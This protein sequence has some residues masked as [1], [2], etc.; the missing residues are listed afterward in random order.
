MNKVVVWIGDSGLGHDAIKLD[1]A[2]DGLGRNCTPKPFDCTIEPLRTWV[3][4]EPVSMY[5]TALLDCLLKSD[6]NVRKGIEHVLNTEG[7]LGFFLEA[8][9]ALAQSWETLFR[10]PDEFFS[11]KPKWR[12][13]RLVKPDEDPE[14]TP[15]PY[16]S[17]LR[18][19]A[20]LSAPQINAGPE[21][22]A[23]YDA[24]QQAANGGL[25]I[26]LHVLIGQEDL[27][28]QVQVLALAQAKPNNLTLTVKAMP[29]LP[30][31]VEAELKAFKPHILHFFCHGKV[32]VGV[33]ELCLADV[34]LWNKGKTYP[35]TIGDLADNEGV[36]GSWLVVVNACKGAM[37]G[38][39]MHSLTHALVAAGVPA[40]IGMME[41]VDPVDANEF[42]RYLFPAVFAEIS[43]A[44]ERLRDQSPGV[45][46]ELE[47]AKAM[48]PP[49]RALSQHERNADSANEGH[50]EI[51]FSHRYREWTVPV[52]HVRR[53]GFHVRRTAAAAPPKAAKTIFEDWLSSLPPE[54]KSRVTTN[55]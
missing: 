23:L 26:S 34:T 19:M 17:P 52:L 33:R 10:G 8:D 54:V 9:S 47:W 32:S 24:V 51:D 15:V 28:D 25:S 2:P 11:L 31:G 38:S 50:A 3:T 18:V 39:D 1:S 49:R 5:G 21:W 41:Q 30:I 7:T 37:A 29:D 40:A 43:A 27:L 13:A 45:A 44:Y 46:A 36:K 6:E 22:T 4:P 42:T 55:Q 12:I 53:Q 35:M 16:E 20:L 48:Y 14:P